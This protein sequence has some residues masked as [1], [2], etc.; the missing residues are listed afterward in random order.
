M[1]TSAIIHTSKYFVMSKHLY[2]IHLFLIASMYHL[3]NFKNYSLFSPIQVQF[4]KSRVQL[5]TGLLSELGVC[6][7]HWSSHHSHSL[8]EPETEET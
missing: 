8:F 1:H 6:V 2:Y 5:W 4:Q 3:S 7:E